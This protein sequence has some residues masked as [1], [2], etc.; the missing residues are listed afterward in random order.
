M[1]PKLDLI[2]MIVRDMPKALAFYRQLGWDIPA[3]L[4]KEGHAEYV[5][6]NGLRIAWDTHDVIRSFEPD[7]Q[8]PSGS[9]RIGMA[10]LCESPAAVDAQ[11]ARLTGMG[12]HA[13]KAPFDA[14]WGQRYAQVEDPDGNVVDLFAALK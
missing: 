8:P 6:P 11:F 4:D 3:E 1:Q 10:F 5:L 13:H 12:Y 14:F 7:W 2:G 9:H